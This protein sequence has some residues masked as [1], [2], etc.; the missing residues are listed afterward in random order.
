M[1]L[2]SDIPFLDVAALVNFVLRPGTSLSEMTTRYTQPCLAIWCH[3]H[4]HIGIPDDKK[5][6]SQWVHTL[7]LL[8]MFP[9]TIL[10]DLPSTKENSSGAKWSVDSQSEDRRPN[11]VPWTLR[12]QV[13]RKVLIHSGEFA[14]IL[15][16]VFGEPN[17]DST[18]HSPHTTIVLGRPARS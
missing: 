7:Y 2:Q 18:I 14:C 9:D 10:L 12:T 4:C 15:N 3:G 13:E 16:D 11:S 17:I 1:A 5:P 6:T 8:S